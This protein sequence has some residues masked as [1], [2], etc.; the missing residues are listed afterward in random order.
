M[1]SPWR[2]ITLNLLQILIKLQFPKVKSL[3]TQELD[4]WLKDPEKS[5]PLLLDARSSEEYALSHL[6]AAQSFTFVQDFCRD[7]P[8]PAASA[9]ASGASLQRIL[10]KQI[11]QP[12]KK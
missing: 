1:F 6:Q 7:A 2:T 12:L 9:L 5:N 3:T 4:L 8:E 11:I 10:G